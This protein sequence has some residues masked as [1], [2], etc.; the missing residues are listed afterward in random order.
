MRKAKR[1]KVAYSISLRHADRLFPGRITKIRP[2]DLTSR[3]VQFKQSLLK[4][5]YDAL[6]NTV[7]K[8]FEDSGEKDFLVER[9]GRAVRFI[10]L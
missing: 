5:E 10:R 2:E 6:I 9:N 1:P 7:N 3:A 8:M 4:R